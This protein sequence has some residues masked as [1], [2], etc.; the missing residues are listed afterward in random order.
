LLAR[1][2]DRQIIQD[3]DG[4]WIERERFAE[5]VRCGNVVSLLQSLRS[6]RQEL[7]ELPLRCG[8]IVFYTL[9]PK[10]SADPRNK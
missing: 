8:V 2:G 10:R 7:R 9:T 6:L 1:K 4:L 5:S 3:R